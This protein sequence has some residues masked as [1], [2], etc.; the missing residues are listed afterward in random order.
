MIVPEDKSGTA[1]AWILP[2]HR[3]FLYTVA[4]RRD[5]VTGAETR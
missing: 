2:F 5:K 1:L 4:R 3:D